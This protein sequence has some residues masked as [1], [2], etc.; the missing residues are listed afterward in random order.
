MKTPSRSKIKEGG[1][2]SSLRRC[3]IGAFG[4][5][6]NGVAQQRKSKASLTLPQPLRACPLGMGR[7]LIRDQHLPPWASFRRKG[8]LRQKCP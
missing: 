1:G 3:V 5:N 2:G 4:E 8:G 6:P 7:T